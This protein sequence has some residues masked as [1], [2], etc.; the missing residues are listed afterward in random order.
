MAGHPVIASWAARPG[1]EKG[2]KKREREVNAFMWHD[3]V[4]WLVGT[5]ELV[6]HSC[7]SCLPSMG[8]GKNR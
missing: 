7:S 4:T 3:D 5:G 1:R 8:A 6:L 2:V